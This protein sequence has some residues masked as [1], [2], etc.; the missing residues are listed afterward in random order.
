M[1]DGFAAK[2]LKTVFFNPIPLK[3]SDST[4]CTGTFFKSGLRCIYS[5][6]VILKLVLQVFSI[7]VTS[8]YAPLDVII[9]IFEKARAFSI[10]DQSVT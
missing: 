10:Y 4:C 8:F 7:K 3:N 2:M 6:E 9:D 1:F 5:H